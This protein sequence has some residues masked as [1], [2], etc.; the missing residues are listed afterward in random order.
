MELELTDATLLLPA[1]RKA[2]AV[3]GALPRLEAFVAATC[4]LLFR[5]V[6][7]PGALQRLEAL[8][9][10]AMCEQ[11]LHRTKTLRLTV[12]CPTQP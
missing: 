5:W 3:L 2:L 1:L 10:A 9:S 11:L 12:C 8:V 7:V 4:E 6:A